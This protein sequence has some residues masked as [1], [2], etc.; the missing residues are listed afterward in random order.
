MNP[1]KLKKHLL[2][3]TFYDPKQNA[4][5]PAD[6]QVGRGAE[7]LSPA[8]V[9]QLFPPLEVSRVPWLNAWALGSAK[10][11]LNPGINTM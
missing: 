1:S 10:P 4:K 2:C 11:D 3:C 8:F 7:Y 9:T 6:T 5:Q